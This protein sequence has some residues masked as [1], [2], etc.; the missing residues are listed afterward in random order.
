MTSAPL[1]RRDLLRAFAAGATLAATGMP[2]VGA[3]GNTRLQSLE[4]SHGGRLGVFALDTGS[5]R[6]L[7]WR[8]DER[9]GMCSTFKLLLAAAVLREADA[10]RLRL[11]EELPFGEHD[12]VPHAPVVQQHLD[13][14]AMRIDA[15]AEAAQTTSDNVAANLL[16]RRLGGPPRVTALFRGLGDAQARIDRYEP[17][18]NLVAGDDPRDTTTPRSMAETAARLMHGD[19]LSPPSRDRL[20]GWMIATATGLRRLRA[21]IPADWIAGDKTGTGISPQMPNRHND[22]AVAWPPGRHAIAIASYYEAP[23]HYPAMRAPDDAV[24]A[25]VGRIVA[26]AFVA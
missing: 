26:A 21:G 10:G 20:R 22:V 17:S 4:R 8:G 3:A 16:I 11:D 24:H 13:A 1:S 19:V 25:E 5:G 15:L 2:R 6:T 23:G 12:L 18:M 9:F 7:S 14:G